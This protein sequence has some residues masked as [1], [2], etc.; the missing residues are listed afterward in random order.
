MKEETFKVPAN[1]VCGGGSQIL[2]EAVEQWIRK[3][4]RVANRPKGFA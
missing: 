3:T 1:I 2:A 4:Q